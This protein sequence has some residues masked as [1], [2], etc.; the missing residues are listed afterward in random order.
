MLTHRI[1]YPTQAQHGG[2][3]TSP[4]LALHQL[5]THK[6]NDGKLFVIPVFSLGFHINTH[7]QYNTPYCF[8]SRWNRLVSF[9][10]CPHA[11]LARSLYS[12]PV[13]SGGR[14]PLWSPS[15]AV[16]NR[17]FSLW[18]NQL[19]VGDS[20][21]AQVPEY[22]E[23]QTDKDKQRS[24]QHKEV[25]ETERRKY[26]HQQEDNSNHVENQSQNQEE[27]ASTQLCT[28]HIVNT[29]NVQVTVAWQSG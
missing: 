10:E 25:P 29:S 18:Q 28:R 4:H 2:N 16:E 26:P 22:P 14:G 11:S 23:N 6:P 1:V 20:E 15:H 21:A 19:L 9:S 8:T 5:S 12:C 17:G 27:G 24:W 7:I 3:D 13:P